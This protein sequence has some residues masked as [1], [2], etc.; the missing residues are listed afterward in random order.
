MSNIYE[1][2]NVT[3]DYELSKLFDKLDLS[4]NEMSNI[5]YIVESLTREKARTKI[6]ELMA[7]SADGNYEVCQEQFAKA[8]KKRVLK[9]ASGLNLNQIMEL[10]QLVELVAAKMS[11]NQ[12]QCLEGIYNIISQKA[13]VNAAKTFIGMVQQSSV[14]Q[15]SLKFNT[16]LVVD[17][18][19][20]AQVIYAL[21]NEIEIFCNSVKKEETEKEEVTEAADGYSI[22]DRTAGILDINTKEIKELG[23]GEE[24]KM[25][26][27]D[28]MN[29]KVRFGFQPT[30][31][32]GM[33]CYITAAD[34]GYAYN[35]RKII[36]RA[37]P[38]INVD[39]WNLEFKTDDGQI[40]FVKLDSDGKQIFENK[41]AQHFTSE[42]IHR[43]MIEESYNK[44]QETI[45][46]LNTAIDSVN[47]I[48]VLKS[49]SD[50]I[51]NLMAKVK[52]M[53]EANELAS[54]K[55]SLETKMNSLMGSKPQLEESCLPTQVVANACGEDT[56]DGLLDGIK[57]T[58]INITVNKEGDVIPCEDNCCAEPCCDCNDDCC[59]EPQCDCIDN[60]VAPIVQP[61]K[62]SPTAIDAPIL[63]KPNSAEVTSAITA[64][65]SHQNDIKSDSR[66]NNI[67]NLQTINTLIG[68][69]SDYF[70]TLLGESV[71]KESVDSEY[72][73]GD[74]VIYKSNGYTYTISNQRGSFY[75]LKDG[76]TNKVYP[77]SKATLKSHFKK[78]NESV[79]LDE[80][81]HKAHY[82][83]GDEIKNINTGDIYTIDSVNFDDNMREYYYEISKPYH[84][85]DDESAKM[86]YTKLE[87]DLDKFCV[88]YNED[89]DYWDG[90]E[91]D[92]GLAKSSKENNRSDINVND[93]RNSLIGK[94]LKD[95]EDDTTWEIVDVSSDGYENIIKMRQDGDEKIYIA[96]PFELK[97][98]FGLDID[99]ILPDDY[100]DGEEE[101]LDEEINDVQKVEYRVG[102]RF[103][104]RPKVMVDG[105]EQDNPFASISSGF[106]INDIVEPDSNSKHLEPKYYIGTLDYTT[107]DEWAIPASRFNLYFEYDTEDN[108]WDGEEELDEEQT[109][110]SGN[111][112]VVAYDI[113]VDDYFEGEYNLHD[114]K[115]LKIHHD[116]N[117]SLD[118]EIK[119]AILEDMGESY[120]G[121]IK[122]ID[123]EYQIVDRAADDQLDEDTV[124][125][126]SWYEVEGQKYPKRTKNGV[127]GLPIKETC[128][129]GATCAAS[130]ATV[131]QPVG[132][133][134]TKKRKPETVDVSLFKE[135]I[136]ND[137]PAS[138]EINGKK[139][140]YKINEGKGYLYIDNGIAKTL[141]KNVILETVDDIY[142]NC[143]D[144]DV[145]E[146]FNSYDLNI[147]LEEENN[148]D[149]GQ[150]DT[151]TVITPEEKKK[152]QI[153]LDNEL[154]LNPNSKINIVSDENQQNIKKNQEFV[155]IDDHDENNKKYVVKDP[156]TG[157]VTIADYNQ[158]KLS[159][160]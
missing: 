26:F 82:R 75:D 76:Y 149:L 4:Y 68:K 77:V 159:E 73:V 124:F 40:M 143:L 115:V 113:V 132:Q 114:K 105:K 154:N 36:A 17:G 66:E 81:V 106:R 90:E 100:D 119:E 145:L 102:D 110:P 33:V 158:V 83:K 41:N 51:N 57:P 42:D 31:K 12:Q 18:K 116:A 98:M 79:A 86:I 109:L 87:S 126:H 49:I 137:L 61:M 101:Q 56:F 10:N 136:Q 131:S 70:N 59:C 24:H 22:L 45:D 89:E 150:T 7:G 63:R 32:L 21:K 27:Q 55:S 28:Y 54:V 88:P 120:N 38:N 58:V 20:L 146:G 71:I 103:I 9:E 91:L 142:N 30:Q 130:V 111:Y 47:D 48:N 99:N 122:V 84:F 46:E 29:G 16:D 121:S 67:E 155:G 104:P 134:K 95:K 62:L 108:Y 160:I 53:N 128:S 72:K 96:T 147:L 39:T 19:N 5:D 43:Q 23:K 151:T 156:A 3:N 1:V 140:S 123:Y 141:D 138:L 153:E 52:N 127:E 13:G 125:D 117:T 118:E 157:K 64:L 80:T 35:A 6:L 11:A 133:K 74:K 93:Y 135:A 85:K 60:C 144:I 50:R 69:I 2:F 92:E 94:R 129:A 14:N 25:T 44:Y 152:Q 139:V 78:L 112:T 34:K 37:Y 8:V 148:D 15:S 97:D 65:A 107:E